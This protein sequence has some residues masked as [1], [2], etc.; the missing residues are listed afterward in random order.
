MEEVTIEKIRV[1]DVVYMKLK[2]D[3]SFGV[4][5]RLLVFCGHQ[6]TMNGN[7]P[8]RD[9]LYVAR[10]YEKI[11]PLRERYRKETYKIPRPEFFVFYNGQSDE[12]TEFIQKLSDAYLDSKED[13]NVSLE[14]IVKVI[15]INT[16][17]G[18]ELLE[19][20]KVLEEYSRFVEKVW[21]YKNAGVDDYM[22]SAITYCIKNH[23]LEEYLSRKGSEVVNFLCAEYD[24]EMDLQVH[25]EEAYERGMAAGL[26][27]G[28]QQVMI[29]VIK[30]GIK[31]KKK[32][33]EV[34]EQLVRYFSLT[35]T[36]AKD[37]YN[38]Y[39]I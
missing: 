33:N 31:D 36:E 26:E 37:M 13:D 24:Y 34:L 20:C 8:L 12:K 9:L 6:S 15:N 22:K 18:N 1:D 35:D 21:E 30:E 2:N 32:E 17:A 38:L 28:R 10:T 14:L 39:S 16:K 3:V 27:Q 25:E 29:T 5:N 7:M 4:N 11:V 19:K 23:I